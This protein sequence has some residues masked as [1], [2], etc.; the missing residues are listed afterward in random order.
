MAI[1]AHR[2]RVVLAPALF[3]GVLVLLPGLAGCG[4]GGSKTPAATVT[5]T[6]GSG[7]SSSAQSWQ[8]ALGAGVTVTE[9]GTPAPGFGSPGAAVRGVADSQNVAECRYF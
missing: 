5:P 3:T 9:P 7:P 1:G 6:A 4:A 2:T 8:Q